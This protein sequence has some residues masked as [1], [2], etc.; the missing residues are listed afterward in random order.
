M[1]GLHEIFDSFAVVQKIG[2]SFMKAED[3]PIAHRRG[4][5]LVSALN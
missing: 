1:Q 5:L 4:P 3:N 2:T